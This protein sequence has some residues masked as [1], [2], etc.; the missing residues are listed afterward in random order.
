MWSQEQKRSD[1]ESDVEILT[2]PI[3]RRWDQDR[4][5]AWL[6]INK[7]INAHPESAALPVKEE[8]KPW[9]AGNWHVIAE[10]KVH[11][12]HLERR[13]GCSH[14]VDSARKKLGHALVMQLRDYLEENPRIIERCASCN[15]FFQA[16][17]DWHSKYVKE[18]YGDIVA[19]ALFAEGQTRRQQAKE[20][21][22]KAKNQMSRIQM[23]SVALSL[24]SHSTSA[25][26]L[27]MS[28]Q[29]MSASSTFV[30]ASGQRV[31]VT[32]DSL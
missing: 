12:E 20:D 16:T 23:V 9:T 19:H 10:I 25:F 32:I 26:D 3:V 31:T 5:R 11:G 22:L 30:N 14:N 15:E 28:G 27:L 24:R 2:E 7:W 4:L 18:E 21:K 13:Q 6:L 1:N 29:T 17:S 8:H